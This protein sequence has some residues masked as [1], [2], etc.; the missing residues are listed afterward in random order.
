MILQQDSTVQVWGY[1]DLT[2][3]VHA[4]LS[5]SGKDGR[6]SYESVFVES[7]DGGVWVMKLP[8]RPSWNRCD[9]EVAI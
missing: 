6:K 4:S 8:S 1:D 3:D 7:F 2:N 5:C 9:I